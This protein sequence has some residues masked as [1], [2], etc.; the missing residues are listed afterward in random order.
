MGDSFFT[1]VWGILCCVCFVLS[2]QILLLR[3]AVCRRISGCRFEWTLD[4][5]VPPLVKIPRFRSF[6]LWLPSGCDG[7]V[8]HPFLPTSPQCQSL[9][10]SNFRDGL[11]SVLSS[12][13]KLCGDP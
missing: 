8:T 10:S 2:G 9:E 6:A 11:S 3:T 7:I 13:W 4:G 1:P 12:F 5:G